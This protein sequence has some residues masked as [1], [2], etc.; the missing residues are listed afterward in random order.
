MASLLQILILTPIPSP[1]PS[2]S[3]PS[4][5]SSPSSPPRPSLTALCR[6]SM[7]APSSSSA[8]KS[9]FTSFFPRCVTVLCIQ[10]I[11]TLILAI[12]GLFVFLVLEQWVEELGFRGR[13]FLSI[14]EDI[15]AAATVGFVVP[16]SLTEWVRRR[17][18]GWDG[19]RKK[20]MNNTMRGRI[21]AD[22]KT[23]TT[24]ATARK[25]GRPKISLALWVVAVATL[26][27]TSTFAAIAA[28][29]HIT[30]NGNAATNSLA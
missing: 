18:G 25:M 30:T 13:G 9:A 19:R 20:T 21:G 12:L 23:I 26:L 6:G 4:S 3:P 24:P 28:Q 16:G 17:E 11:Q 15:G 22:L 7:V 14:C 27:V 29:E 5:P 1:P 8:I 10:L 2:R